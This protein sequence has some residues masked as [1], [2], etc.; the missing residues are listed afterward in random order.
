MAPCLIRAWLAVSF[1]AALSIQ[2]NKNERPFVLMFFLLNPF[3]WIEFVSW[4]HHDAI[5][6]FLV[7]F[8]AVEIQKSRQIF[9][10]ILI[11]LAILLKFFPIF[12]IP[13]FWIELRRNQIIWN[14][15]FLMSCFITLV[16][17]YEIAYLYWGKS[18][19]YPLLF[20]SNRPPAM[21]SIFNFFQ[22]RIFDFMP[23]LPV[24]QVMAI[25]SFLSKTLMSCGAGFVLFRYLN[26]KVSRNRA[27]AAMALVLFLFFQVGH[28]QFHSSVFFILPLILAEIPS[29]KERLNVLKPF[30]FYVGLLI[31]FQ[32]SLVVFGQ[33]SKTISYLVQWIAIPYLFIGVWT[34]NCLLNPVSEDG[35]GKGVCIMGSCS[36]QFLIRSV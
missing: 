35:R 15:R 5:V 29:Q 8:A 24:D 22:K 17:G 27:I 31:A 32:V 1:Y 9:S 11:G 36:Q 2:W 3:F 13:F 18:V 16:V 20:A 12:L 26:G 10:G 28:P 6:A 25:L 19:F 14:L 30:F 23:F 33:Y 21:L 4:G 7:F 34:I